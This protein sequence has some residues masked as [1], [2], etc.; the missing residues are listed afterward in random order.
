MYL[1][2]LRI[3]DEDVRKLIELVDEPTR[4]FSRSRSRLRPKWSR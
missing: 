3:P 2:G 1:A 4:A